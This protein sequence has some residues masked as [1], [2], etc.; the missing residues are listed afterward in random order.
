[1][2][3][4]Q[5][6]TQKIFCNSADSDQ[7]A[8]FGSMSTG[9]PIYSNDVEQLQSNEAYEVGWDAATLE[10]KAPFM[11]EM[12]GVQYGLTYQLAYNFQEGIP[13]YDAETTYYIGSIVKVLED[14]KPVL[15][16]SLT[17]ENLG[18]SLTDGTNWE[19]LQLGGGS[20]YQLFDTVLKDHVLTYEETKGWALQGTYVYKEALAGSRYGYPDFYNKCLEERNAVS[21][22]GYIT[23]NT[24]TQPT[25]PSGI[26]SLDGWSNVSNAFDG[27]SST[28]ATISNTTGYLEWDLGQNLSVS[29]F[30]ATGLWINSQAMGTDL[31]IYSVDSNGIEILL[32]TSTGKSNSSSPYTLTCSFTPIICSKLRFKATDASASTPPRIAEIKLTANELVPIYTNSNGHQYYDIANKDAV[33]EFFSTMG[34]AWFY[35]VDTANERIFL[36]RN[37]FFDQATGDISEVGQSVEAGLPNITGTLVSWNDVGTFSRSQV[38]AFANDTSGN[39]SRWPASDASSDSTR[40]VSFNA[41][42]SS[43]IYGNSNTVQPN[44]VKKLLYICVGNTTNYEGVTEV[45]NQ[46]MEI[47]E[48][49]N[50][51]IESRVAKDSMQEVP[52]ITATYING[53]SGYNIYSNGYCEQWGRTSATE[54]LVTITLL[55]AFKDANYSVL[56]SGLYA[57][58]NTANAWDYVRNVTATSFGIY[59]QSGGCMWQAKG[60]IA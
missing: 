41:S 30:T 37:N 50:Q 56:T 22:T 14:N 36:P 43:A 29:G 7:I 48:Q 10:D 32:G 60:Y 17:D 51:G 20:G 58:G 1:M 35:G 9:T 34:S 44:A 38:G 49:V 25:N 16:T 15:Y 31:S 59:Q 27:N 24:W 19:R 57:S 4:I 8:V 3:K 11:E 55:K 23:G 45:V 13:E 40:R 18:N 47:L 21:S 39:T 26:S 5:R 53:V 46:G 52:C 54:G 33:D 6:K 28:Y 12:N 2:P 42:R